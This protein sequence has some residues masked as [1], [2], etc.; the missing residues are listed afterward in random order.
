MSCHVASASHRTQS[1]AC[2]DVL[3]TVAL[4]AEGARVGEA[5]PAAVL[6]LVDIPGRTTSALIVR[7]IYGKRTSLRD[8]ESVVLEGF[9]RTEI[10]GSVDPAGDVFERLPNGEHFLPATSILNGHGAAGY[11]IDDGPWVIVPAAHFAGGESYC[12]KRYRGGTAKNLRVRSVTNSNDD[13]GCRI[14]NDAESDE[15]DGDQ[16]YKFGSKRIRFHDLSPY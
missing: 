15:A 1:L 9:F 16:E 11:D 2:V 6:A 4:V 10:L 13:D 3:N 12:P 14:R 5:Y 7:D 8:N